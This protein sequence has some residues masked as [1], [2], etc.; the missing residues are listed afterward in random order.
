MTQQTNTA[1]MGAAPQ[2]AQ[3]IIDKIERA[4]HD[5][6][7][8]K[9]MRTNGPCYAQVEVT[10]LERLLR[11]YLSTPAIPSPV[12]QDAKAEQAPTWPQCVDMAMFSDYE[13]RALKAEAALAARPPVAAPDRAADGK[14]GGL[15][16]LVAQIDF[17]TRMQDAAM[18]EAR[19][20][21]GHGVTRSSICAIFKAAIKA[22]HGASDLDAR[23]GFETWKSSRGEA[24]SYEGDGQYGAFGVNAQFE[25]FAAGV[26]TILANLRPTASGAVARAPAPDAEAI[27]SALEKYV[28]F[29]K[30]RRDE[31]GGLSD[32]MEAVDAIARAALSQPSPAVKSAEKGAAQ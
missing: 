18:D 7:N 12:A 25:A 13:A 8:P 5:A 4:I 6:K 22:T 32:E 30:F 10:C 27:R 17:N 2:V 26:E 29:A 21:Y 23:Q 28:A 16:T 11:A 14:T 31:L 15:S 24:V 3:F 1:P 19:N 20:Q 9:G